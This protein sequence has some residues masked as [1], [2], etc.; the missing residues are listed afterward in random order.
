MA[1]TEYAIKMPSTHVL[2]HHLHGLILNRLQPDSGPWPRDGDLSVIYLT[3][4]IKKI[5]NYNIHL[6]IFYFHFVRSLFPV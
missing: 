1:T 6:L 4:L 5:S 2:T 3:I